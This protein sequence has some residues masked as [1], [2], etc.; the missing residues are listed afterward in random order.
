MYYEKRDTTK[1]TPIVSISFAVIACIHILV[2]AFVVHFIS[3]D[4]I[5][6]PTTVLNTAVYFTS[7]LVFLSVIVG[8]KNKSSGYIDMLI[9]CILLIATFFLIS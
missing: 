6:Y 3:I 1:F 7:F 2:T 4:E 5:G 9:A 8:L